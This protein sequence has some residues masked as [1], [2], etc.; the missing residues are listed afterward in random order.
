MPIIKVHWKSLG[1]LNTLETGAWAP[2]QPLRLNY[3]LMP[4]VSVWLLCEVRN[5]G[6]D[7]QGQ[8]QGVHG[9]ATEA[10]HGKSPGRTEARLHKPCI[11]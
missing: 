2:P 8:D 11:V 4:S 1:R 10:A 5:D 6:N 7:C 3:P 9:P